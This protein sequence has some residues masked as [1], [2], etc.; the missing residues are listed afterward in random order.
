MSSTSRKP[1]G[2]ITAVLLFLVILVAASRSMT[3]LPLPDPVAM[4]GAAGLLPPGT[5]GHSWGTDELGRDVLSRVVHGLS[6]TVLVS[7]V[8]LVTALLI[9]TVLGGLAG[10]F[11]GGAVDAAVNWAADLVLSLPFLLVTAAILSVTSLGLGNAYAVL[12]GIMWVHPARIIRAEVARRREIAYIQAARALGV[13]EWRI[14]LGKLLPSATRPA[15]LLSVSYLPEVIAL[16]A[17]LSF[18]GLGV[19]PPDPGLGKMIFDG[20]PYVFSAWWLTVCPASTLF[21]VV[22]TINVFTLRATAAEQ[23]T[24]VRY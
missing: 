20:L 7:I 16:E 19:Q 15:I 4:T 6:T 11:A 14:V 3:W 9:G 22:L 12:A 23:L 17:G 21:V 10:Y 13:G 18:V 1:A 2:A 5:P 8:A 24:S